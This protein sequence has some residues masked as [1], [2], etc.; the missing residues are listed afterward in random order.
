MKFSTGGP[1]PRE[2]DITVDGKRYRSRTISGIFDQYARSH[3]RSGTRLPLD[4]ED[5]V[6][7]HLAAAYP[8]HVKRAPGAAKRRSVS[9]RQALNFIRFLAKRVTDKRLVASEEARRRA[10]ICSA[11]PMA[12]RVSGCSVCK[13]ALQLTI[14]PPEEVEAPEACGACGCYLPLKVWLPLDQLGS[15]DDFDYAPS[16]WM[17]D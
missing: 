6:W 13:D 2:F 5:L 11:C 7:S 9:M 12:S 14:H 1:V 8:K 3:D 4:W 10:S 16:C 17:R 15:A